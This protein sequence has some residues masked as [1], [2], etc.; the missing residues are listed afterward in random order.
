MFWEA[1]RTQIFSYFGCCLHP[2]VDRSERGSTQDQTL[3]EQRG[4]KER[5]WGF[6]I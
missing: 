3:L 5:H 1:D 2:R 4:L 6:L